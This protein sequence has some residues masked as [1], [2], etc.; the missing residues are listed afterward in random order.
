VP[1]EPER[2]ARNGRRFF[3][4]AHKR[5]VVEGCLAPGA[6]VS[7][8][9]LAHGF[10]TNLVRKWIR[11]YQARQ[12]AGAGKLVPVTVREAR[13]IAPS[14][15]GRAKPAPAQTV[16]DSCSRLLAKHAAPD[17]SDLRG[18]SLR[19]AVRVVDWSFYLAA[20]VP[21][22][23]LREYEKLGVAR[24]MQRSPAFTRASWLQRPEPCAMRSSA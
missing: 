4:E 20:L 10:N 14:G 17:H 7:A 15:R 24:A 6:S 18:C 23:A 3:S 1:V 2:V 9:S 5:A 13:E 8:V 12:A 21:L 19:V 11:L 22:A 16:D